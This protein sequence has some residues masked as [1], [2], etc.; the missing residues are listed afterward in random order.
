MIDDADALAFEID[1]LIES[2][3]AYSRALSGPRP[4]LSGRIFLRGDRISAL[5]GRGASTEPPITPGQKGPK[6]IAITIDIDTTPLPGACWHVLLEQGRDRSRAPLPAAPR[7]SS[8][9]TSVGPL[10]SDAR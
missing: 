6:L 3:G 9:D 1:H 7:P 5:D 2:L 10:C 4:A 8:T